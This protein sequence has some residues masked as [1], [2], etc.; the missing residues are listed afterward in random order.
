MAGF[1]S[2]ARQVRDP[3]SDLALRRYSLRKCLERF[4]PYGHRATWDH[5]CSRAGFGPEDRSPD[6]ARLVAALDELQAARTVWL[7]Y[8]ESFA[9]RRRREKHDGLRRPG[10]VDDWH[11]CTWGGHG[12]AWCDDPS[13]HPSAPL[14]DVLRRLIT[15]LEREPGA[16]CPVCGDTALEWR[17]GLAH[18]PSA[19]PVCTGCGIV[20]PAPVLTPE[21][22]RRSRS[23]S[24]VSA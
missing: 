12:V 11:R 7:A 2:L 14:G 24:L 6:P 9:R 10:S 18:V 21:A 15:A 13:V 8:E 22:V 5:L 20:V 4:A 16:A 3:H 17:Y 1:R 19:G 23:R